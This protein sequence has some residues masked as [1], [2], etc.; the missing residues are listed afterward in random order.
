MRLRLRLV[1]GLFAIIGVAGCQSIGPGSVQRDRM[2]YA[3]AMGDSWKQQMLLNIVKFRYFDTPV[4]LDISSVISSY[5]L[6]GEGSFTENIFPHAP[7][8]ASRSIGLSGTYTDSPTITYTPLTGEKFIDSL[9]K[10][11]PPQTIFTMIEAGHPADFIFQLTVKAINGIANG[12]AAPQRGRAADPRFSLIVAALRRIQQAGA[13][14]IRTEKG[15]EKGDSDTEK[16]LVFFKTGVSEDTDTDIR[17]LKVTL[18]LRQQNDE[19]ELTFASVHSNPNEL[20][21]F[22]RSMQ[23]ILVELGSGVQVPQQDLSDGRATPMPA[24]IQSGKKSRNPRSHFGSKFGR[25]PVE[26]E[27][28]RGQIALVFG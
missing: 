23:E 11:L 10:P 13:L 20:A 17:F 21:L 27:I 24:A 19:F 16:T 6:Q 15:S 14:G 28:F 12:S 5:Q 8:S 4:F 1:V 18:G 2:D 22:T 3:G 26:V 7:T 25:R 9:L